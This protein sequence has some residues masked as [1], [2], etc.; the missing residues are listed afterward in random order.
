MTF[1]RWT[2]STYDLVGL[3][4]SAGVTLSFLIFRWFLKFHKN[5]KLWM[6]LLAYLFNV[7]AI[8]VLLLTGVTA[9][10]I[11]ERIVALLAHFSTIDIF[12]ILAWIIGIAVELSAIYAIYSLS[13]RLYRLSPR[14]V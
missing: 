13:Y 1:L 11:T 7:F 10:G 14:A 6:R 5:A 2:L 12:I 9:T 4:I 8:P 3:G